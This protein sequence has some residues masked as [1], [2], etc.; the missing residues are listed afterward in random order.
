MYNKLI[1]NEDKH[2]KCTANRQ[3]FVLYPPKDIPI[4]LTEVFFSEL[5]L[6]ITYLM[7]YF[8]PTGIHIVTLP[9]SWISPLFLHGKAVYISDERIK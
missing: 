9:G 3:P 8:S 6:S 1:H 2:A 7:K 4:N 5:Y